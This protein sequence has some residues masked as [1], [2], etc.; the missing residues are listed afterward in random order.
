MRV[1]WMPVVPSDN[2]IKGQ[3]QCVG[4][5]E[6]VGGAAVPILHI[7]PPPQFCWIDASFQELPFVCPAQEGTMM[8]KPT[9]KRDCCVG[10]RKAAAA[11]RLFIPGGWTRLHNSLYL[12][13]ASV[14]VSDGKHFWLAGEREIK[15]KVENATLKET[16]TPSP[17]LKCRDVG[18]SMIVRFTVDSLQDAP[19]TFR[20]KI[21][22]WLT[23]NL[24][25][26]L[27]QR[28]RV[29]PKSQQQFE[30]I[31]TLKSEVVTRLLK[32]DSPFFFDYDLEVVVHQPLPEEKDVDCRCSIVA[33]AGAPVDENGNFIT[34]AE[35]YGY[36]DKETESE[37]D[38]E[39]I[40]LAPLVLVN[41][42]GSS[43]KYGK[44]LLFDPDNEKVCEWEW[45]NLKCMAHNACDSVLTSPK[46]IAH[47]ILTLVSVRAMR[48][49]GAY[50]W[51]FVGYDDCAWRY[52]D[53]R[54]RKI[55]EAFRRPVRVRLKS[56]Q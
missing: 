17:I 3:W 24:V 48:K 21:Y 20:L 14:T 39:L 27:E 44:C 33:E 9:F 6:E 37:E 43:V 32:E 23:D 38:D 41:R 54:P 31:F 10:E 50:Y 36:E 18:E 45:Q 30:F 1:H 5:G 40:F 2:P 13:H 8:A 47:N 22:E 35:Y 29:S 56:E 28:Q 19:A 51:T 46:G 4:E 49:A 16:P 34:S 15:V 7:F 12:L 26:I 55:L 25:A 11:F 42:D 52:K 53:H